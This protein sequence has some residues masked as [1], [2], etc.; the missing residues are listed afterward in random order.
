MTHRPCITL[1]ACTMVITLA[2]FTAPP[3][4]AG[5]LSNCPSLTAC[6]TPGG[7][8]TDAIVKAL[9][10]ANRAFSSKLIALPRRQLRK[11]WWRLKN[12]ASR[13]T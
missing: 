10:E 7:N 11:R 2:L 13:R 12:A 4:N 5:E 8:C 9:R 3:G 6:F 1:M